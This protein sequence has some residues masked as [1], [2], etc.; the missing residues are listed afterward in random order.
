MNC[1]A[2]VSGALDQTHQPSH[3]ACGLK[4]ALNLWHQILGRVGPTLG[5]LVS[6]EDEQDGAERAAMGMTITRVG[7]MMNRGQMTMCVKQIMRNNMMMM[8][9]MMMMMLMMVVMM[10]M[11]TML[12]ML[13]MM[14]MMMLL[15]MIADC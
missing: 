12:M 1:L 8:M 5:S 15:M 11:M 7:I 13:M 6:D 14:P 4:W 3:L 10:M 9:M 2:G